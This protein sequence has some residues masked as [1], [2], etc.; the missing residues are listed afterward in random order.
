M[1]SDVKRVKKYLKEYNLKD[2]INFRNVPLDKFTKKELIKI[3][4]LVFSEQMLR[5]GL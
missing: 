4:T 2:V 5:V 1:I 3:M